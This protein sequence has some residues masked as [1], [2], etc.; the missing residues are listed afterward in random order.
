M[1]IWESDVW[2]TAIRTK[3]G[4]F[5]YQIIPFDLSNVLASFQGYI[6]KI[7]TEKLDIFV[8]VYLDYILIYTKDPGQPPVEVV[9]WLLKQLQKHGLYA[10]LKKCRLYKVKVQFLGFIVLAQGI[11]MEEERIETVK[12]WPESQSVRDIWVFLC[13]VNFYR[14]FIQ[15]FSKI[16]AP[17]TS[18]LQ[19]TVDKA[20]ST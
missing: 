6:N 9:Q 11:K 12:T 4:H 13:F 18:M 19:I 10:N 1:R 17:L 14:R 2:K 16:V 5:K 15:N 20:L 8:V 7:F 3:Y